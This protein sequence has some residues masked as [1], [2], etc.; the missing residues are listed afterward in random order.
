MG[1]EIATLPLGAEQAQ[2]RNRQKQDKQAHECGSNAVHS[3]EIRRTASRM[4]ISATRRATR[5]RPP[6][7]L[8][9]ILDPA[10]RGL[11]L[12]S[13]KEKRT[14][15]TV[16]PANPY[17]EMHER[18]DTRRSAGSG[19]ARGDFV[20]E[21]LLQHKGVVVQRVLPGID[22]RDRMMTGEF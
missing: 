4:Q 16:D 5:L 17:L 8:V 15:A 21:E 9:A 12:L 1:V 19:F 7:P 10:G 14:W 18:W 22:E 3:V 2:E 20:L 13:L 11:V 6:L